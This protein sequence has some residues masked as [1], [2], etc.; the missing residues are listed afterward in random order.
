MPKKRAL[1]VAVVAGAIALIIGLAAGMFLLHRPV[2]IS[3]P[4]YH[5]LTF[6]RG[7]VHSARFAPDGKT[8]IYSAA[9]EGKPLELFTTRPE[10]PD[11]EP[12]E[13]AVLSLIDDAH[14]TAAQLFN[15]AIVGYDLGNHEPPS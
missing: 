13:L 5:P 10:S 11:D 3:L 7:I 9:W 2:Q 12:T 6:R 14:S 4:V 15:N 1:L 8:I